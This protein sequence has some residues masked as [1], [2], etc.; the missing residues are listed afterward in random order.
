MTKKMLENAVAQAKAETRN[1]LQTV[2]VCLR[3]RA[4]THL[5]VSRPTARCSFLLP[6]TTNGALQPTGQPTQNI[7]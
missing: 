4:R 1:A 2:P 6:F 3:C 7:L 5:V